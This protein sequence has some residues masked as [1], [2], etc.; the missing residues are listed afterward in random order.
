MAAKQDA[1]MRFEGLL[2]KNIYP[3]VGGGVTEDMELQ[4]S[5][6]K[7]LGR[8][9]KGVYAADTL[10]S[11]S[12]G[13]PAYLIVN[14]DSHSEPGSHWMGLA[15]SGNSLYFYDSFGRMPADILPILPTYAAK[16]GLRLVAGRSA[17]E[18]NRKQS[19][20]GART[21]AWLLLFKMYGSRVA[22]LVSE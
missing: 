6:K 17:P 19:D 15:K 7:M 2:H 20:C 9:F 4:R 13:G 18:Q 14:A 21:L 1:T 3:L 10:P 5:G 22:K 11:L 12:S 8:A 16:N